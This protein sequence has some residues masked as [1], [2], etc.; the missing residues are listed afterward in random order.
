MEG[1][2]LGKKQNF[3]QNKFIFKKKIIV[4]V[5]ACKIGKVCVTENLS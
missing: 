5:N 1:I 2:L 4:K 3:R